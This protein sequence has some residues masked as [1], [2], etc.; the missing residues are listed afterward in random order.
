[1]SSWVTNAEA[2]GQYPVLVAYDIPW[3]DCDRYSAGG[4]ASPQA[5]EQ[6]INEMVAGIGGRSAA[7]IVEPDALSELGCLSASR[8]QTYYALLRYAVVHLSSNANAAVYIDAGN[9]TWQLPSMAERLK[10]AGVESA[11]GFSL[12]V[13]NFDTT[14]ESIGYGTTLSKELGGS[15]HFVIDTSRNG[16]GPAPEAAWCNPPGRGLGT[17]PT[18]QT[19]S[20]LVDAYLWIKIPGASDGT[21]N[22]GP[23]AGAWWPSYAL[24]LADNS[25]F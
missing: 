25:A 5:Y 17:P 6:W 15:V 3:R 8:Q 9:T 16:R 12:N 4:A 23:A 14:A 22:G 13:S 10:E 2:V 21:C 18:D 7:I 11:R 1:V 20:A 19:A 24:E